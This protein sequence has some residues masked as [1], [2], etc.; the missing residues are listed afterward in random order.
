MCFEFRLLRR[1]RRTNLQHVRTKLERV[2]RIQMISVI[3]HE[4]RAFPASHY[5]H[6]A[7]KRARFPVALRA[8]T[9]ALSHQSLYGKSRQLMKAVQILETRCESFESTFI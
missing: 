7:N 5:F 9:I 2:C 6:K 4:A 1:D 8:E 3:L